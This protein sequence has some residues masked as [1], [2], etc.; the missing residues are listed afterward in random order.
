MTTKVTIKVEDSSHK[1]V[2]VGIV[3]QSAMAGFETCNQ[4]HILVP[5]ET[6]E[7]YVY[8]GQSL[9]VIEAP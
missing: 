6:K 4:I 8:V 5:G 2:H 3:G 1:S 7:F 9:K